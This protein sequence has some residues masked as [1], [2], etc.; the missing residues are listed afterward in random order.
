VHWLCTGL[1][2]TSR[3][4]ALHHGNWGLRLD[5]RRGDMLPADGPTPVSIRLLD[6]RDGTAPVARRS[7][8]AERLFQLMDLTSSGMNDTSRH[9][10]SGQWPLIRTDIRPCQPGVGSQEG[11][12]VDDLFAAASQMEESLH[13]AVT[14]MKGV[15][16]PACLTGVTCR[17]S[18]GGGGHGFTRKGRSGC[19]RL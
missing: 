14:D 4:F 18:K 6:H 11:G 12:H 3:A 16:T 17:S 1:Q 8:V 7:H 15:A 13:G 19:Q 10:S 2:P 9:H 5:C